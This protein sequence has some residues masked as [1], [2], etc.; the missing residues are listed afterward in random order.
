MK[1]PILGASLGEPPGELRLHGLLARWSEAIA[2]AER[3]SI[4]ELLG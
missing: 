4:A 1:I 2:P 3:R